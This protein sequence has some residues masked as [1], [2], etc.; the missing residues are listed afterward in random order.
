MRKDGPFQ[1]K[2]PLRTDALTNFT[3]RAAIDAL[4]A[5]DADAWAALFEK[6]AALFDDGEVRS[7]EKF[8]RDAL[9]HEHF[10]SIEHVGHGGLEVVGQFHSDQWG[11]FRTY[12]RFR[13][14]S[15]GKIGRLDIGQ[16]KD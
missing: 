14:T 2:K 6:D 10:T 12:F 16:T 3:V 9:G 15:A 7:L 11:D 13:L 5:G 8:N 1:A 4:Q